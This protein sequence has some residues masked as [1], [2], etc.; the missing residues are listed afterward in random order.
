M[1]AVDLSAILVAVCQHNYYDS[2]DNL[3]EDTSMVPPA[4]ELRKLVQSESLL[5]W[6]DGMSF[7]PKGLYITASAL[8]VSLLGMKLNSSA[9]FHI[10]K[11]A[12][13]TIQGMQIESPY[14][15]DKLLHFSGQ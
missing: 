3:L 2:D 12:S 5:R 14:Y 15:N 1:T 9:P 13:E 4:F 11:I 6:P 7:G 8:H 10:L